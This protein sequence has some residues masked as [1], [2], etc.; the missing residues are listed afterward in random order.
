MNATAN[1]ESSAARPGAV[2]LV[3][4]FA[5]I[6]LIW[7][8]TYI[9]IRFAIQT[10]PPLLMMGARNFLAGVALFA[11]MRLRGAPSPARKHWMGALVTGILLFLIDHGALAWAEQ[12]IPSSLAA[13]LCATTPFSM[14][15][16]ARLAGQERKISPATWLGLVV[17]LAGV[18]LLVGPDALFHNGST[19]VLGCVVVLIAASAWAAGSIVGRMVPLPDSPAL[20]AGMQMMVGGASLL[21]AGTLIG[22]GARFHP[23]AV[24]FSSLAWF[25]YLVT[26]GSIV[27]FTAYIWLL[28][29][30]PP[31]R[32]ATHAYVNPVV[33]IL[34]GWALADEPIGIRV[35][36]A[37][38]TILAGVA[39]VNST[40]WRAAPDT[41]PTLSK[42]GL[43]S[44]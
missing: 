27:A 6:Y 39:L 22:E 40:K 31:S 13:L 37:A 36:V 42:P 43:D 32:V 14:V 7:G 25:G 23:A 17:G 29:V 8:S 10:I 2:P 38:A 12:R 18:S 4:A 41:A 16:F 1:S 44:V 21:C 33:A 19:D 30:I 5:A 34:L 9:A 15:I 11:W 26:F 20:S 3:A 28:R 35:W 24:T